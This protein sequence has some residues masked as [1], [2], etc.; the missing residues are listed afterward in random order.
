MYRVMII[1]FGLM[2][3]MALGAQAQVGHQGPIP[4]AG[5]GHD[6]TNWITYSNPWGPIEM[7]YTLG[8]VG[9]A[10]WRNCA[11]GNLIT[12]PGLDIEMWIEMECVFTWSAQHVGIHRTSNYDPFELVFTGTSACNNGVAII[13]TPPTGGNLNALLFTSDLL[14]HVRGGGGLYSDDIPLLW[15]YSLDG[16]GWAPMTPNNDPPNS[17]YFNVPSCNHYFAIR[18]VGTP[19]FH[20]ADGYYYLGGQG[21]NICPAEPL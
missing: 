3:V 16:S 21:A 17:I 13:T 11:D 9:G 20:Q 6:C 19:L 12:W 5:W 2:L 1:V 15:T 18:A 8:G 4:P 14:G 10:G 7:C